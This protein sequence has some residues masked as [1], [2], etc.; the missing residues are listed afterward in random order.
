[1]IPLLVW[2]K[3]GWYIFHEKYLRLMKEYVTLNKELYPGGVNTYIC[4]PNY[5]TFRSRTMGTRA[6]QNSSYD[7]Y[8]YVK[9]V[10]SHGFKDEIWGPNMNCKCQRGLLNKLSNWVKGF[11]K[12]PNILNKSWNELP[13]DTFF[14]MK[15]VCVER[16]LTHTCDKEIVVV[17]R[18]PKKYVYS[19]GLLSPNGYKDMQPDQMRNYFYWT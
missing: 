11:G 19:S 6:L 15:F 5:L 2:E 12:T 8:F 13:D 9:S 3:I 16:R 10:G 18:L 1:M 14:R 17:G 7:H 4:L